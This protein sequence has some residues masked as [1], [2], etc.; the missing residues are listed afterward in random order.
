MR[1]LLLLVLTALC[2]HVNATTYYL[3]SSVGNDSNNGTSSSSPWKTLNKL[4]SFAASLKPGDKVLFNRGDIFYGNITITAAGT[5]SSVITYGTYGSG[6]APIIS[7]FSNVTAWTNLGGN[8]WESTNAISGLSSC[9]YVL[10][11]NKSTTMGRTPNAGSFYYYTSH[12]GTTSITSSS[13]NS[14]TTNWT[15]ADIAIWIDRE[16]NLRLPITGHSGN[17]ITFSN[18]VNSGITPVNNFAFFIENDPRTLDAQNEWYYNPSTKKIR[19][20]STS[21]PSNV[22]IATVSDVILGNACDYIV[23]DG[24]NIQGANH[25]GIYFTGTT[26]NVTVQNCTLNYCGYNGIETSNG[27]YD[28]VTYCNINNCGKTGIFLLG[29]YSSATYNTTNHCGDV[30]GKVD[31]GTQGS[32]ILINSPSAIVSYNV[33]KNSGSNG[34]F[35]SNHQIGTGGVVSYNFIDSSLL[36]NTDNGGIYTSAQSV[37]VLIDHNIITNSV[38]K[39]DIASPACANLSEVIYLDEGTG[40]SQYAVVTNNSVAYCGDAGLKIHKNGH[41]RIENNTFFGNI[42][43][44]AIIQDENSTQTITADTLRNNIFFCTNY[45]ASTLE[46]W[47]IQ[48]TSMS[49]NISGLGLFDN[50]YYARPLN[51]GNLFTTQIS[52]G[53]SIRDF[54]GWKSYTGF[55]SHSTLSSKTTTNIND[56]KLVYNNTTST[57]SYALDAVYS[58]LKGNTYNGSVTLNPFNSVALIKTG[59]LAN[60]LPVAH[61]GSDQT[62]TLPINSVTLTA[63]GTDSDGVITAY[64]WTKISGPSGYS[65][66]SPA[67]ATTLVSGL[68]QGIYQFQLTVTDNAGGTGK[69]TV[70]VTVNAAPNQ[71]PVANAGADQAITL[72]LNNISLNGSG[73][74]A[75]GTVVSYQWTK[76][77]GPASYNI[78]SPNSANTSVTG[79]VQGT[80][81]FQLQVTDNNGATGIDVMILTVNPAPNIPPVANAGSNQT[82]ILPV[83]STTLSGSGTDA[84]GTVVGYLW[85]ELSGPSSASIVSSG[86]ASTN[87]TGLVQGTYQFQLQVTDNDGAVGSATVQ[88]IVNP[89]VNIP[90]T[91]NA[92]SNQTITL[93]VNSVTL[94]G[95]GSDADGTVVGYAWTQLSGPSAGN[96]INA[97]STTTNI[98]NLVQGVYQ[99]QLQVTDNSGAVGNASVQVTVNAAANIPPVA[100]A[101]A[102]QVITLPVNSIT[103][104]GSGTDSDGIIVSYQWTELSGPSSYSFA[105]ANSATTNVNGLIQG[106]YQFQLQVTDNVGATGIAVVQVTVNPAANIPPVANAGP[107][108]AINLPTD[109]VM[110]TGSGT[111][112]DGSIVSYQWTE[113]SGPLSYNISNTSSPSTAVTGLIQG[114]YQFQLQVTDNSGATAIASVQ[115]TVNAAANIPPVANAGSNQTIT[116]PSDSVILTGSGTDADGTVVNYLWTKISGPSSYSIT[117]PNAATTNVTGLVQGT[118]QFQLQVTD[119]LGATGTAIVSVTVNASTNIAPVANAGSNQT[120]KLPVDSVKL[121]GSGTDAD[122]TIVSYQWTQTSGPSSYIIINPGNAT[123]EVIGLVSGIYY[124]QLTVTD[125]DGA[126]NSSSVKITV[127]SGSNIPPVANAGT[128]QTI[129]LPTDSITLTGTGTDADGSVVSYQWAKISGPSSSNIISPAS[130][131]TQVTALVQGIYQFQLTVTDNKGAIGTSTVQ[132]TVN[133]AVN[134]PPVADAGPDQ[135]VI[136]PKDSTTVTGSGTDADGTIISYQWSEISGPSSYS[137]ANA[138]AAITSITGLV[139]GVYQFQL[140]VTDNGGASATSIVQITVNPAANIPPVANAGA[141]QVITL[142]LDSVALSGSGTDADGTIVS[143]QWS[144]ISG[145]SSYNIINTNAAT[146]SI[147]GLVQ[148]IYQF[149]LQVTDNNGA[150]GAAV[151][152]ITVNA[153]PNIPPVAN[154]GPDQTITLPASSVTLTGSGSDA[155][156][157]IAS[158]QWTEISGPSAATIAN[159]NTATT[160]VSGLVQ[161]VYQFELQVIDNNGA[162]ASDTVMITVNAA[163]NILPTANA[164][165][166]QT[167]TL[168]VNSVTLTG[169]GTDADGTIVS[170]QWS[171]ISGPAGSTITTPNLPN[172]NITGLVQGVYQFQLTVT[173]N[174]GGTGT[175]SVQVTVNAALN[176]PPVANAG[177]DQSI[178]LPTNSVTLN[179]IGTDIDGTVVS[180]QWSEV[181]GPSSYTI[182][183]ANAALTSITGLVQGVYQFQLKVTDNNGAIATD[184]VQII[185]NPAPNQPPVANAGV[186][187]SITLPVN[188]VTLN[189]SGTDADGSVVAYSWTKISGPASYTIVNANAATTDIT[190]LNKGTYQ[191]QLKVTDNN[192]AIGT[193]VVQIIVNPAPNKPPTAHVNNTNKTVTLP[194]NSTTIS[195]GGTDSDGTIVSYQW[196]L[197]SGPTG[198]VIANAT[199]SATT[200]TNLVQ[201]TYKFQLQVTDN[202]GATANAVM[203]INVDPAPN[204]PPVANAG[205]D[206]VI[207][208]PVNSVTLTGAGTDSDGTVVA[209]QWSKVSGPS[210]FTIANANSDTTNVSGLVAGTYQFQLKVTDNNGASAIDL[211]NV[212]VNPAPNQPPVANAGADQTITLPINTVTLNGIGTDADGSIVSYKWTKVSGPSSFTIVNA[213]AASTNIS[214][215][216]QGTYQFQLEVTDNS[217]AKSDDVM[218][219]TVNPP[220]NQ[221]PTA[222]AGPDQIITLPTNSVILSGSGTDSDGTIAAYQWTKISGPT[223]YSFVS[224][225]AAATIVGGLTAG[226]YL[227]E[228][229]VTDNNGARGRDTVQ[230]IVNPAPNIPPS[231]SAGN[232]QTITLPTNTVSLTGAAVDADGT[233]VAYKWTKISGP[234][235]YNITNANSPVT[236]AWNLT[237]GVYQ[238]VLT[239]TDNSGADASDTVSITVISLANIPPVADAGSDI[240][241]TL[242]Q[243]TTQLAGSGTDADGIIA[244]YSWKQLTGPSQSSLAAPN[245]AYTEV[246]GLIGG[247]YEFEL[248]VTDNLG[249][250]GK[251]T[252]FV[253]VTEPRLNTSVSPNKITA[254]PNPVVDI[255]TLQINTGHVYA[256]L[257]IT[258]ED[259]NGNVIMQRQV[260][261]SSTTITQQINLSNRAKG[262]YVITVYYGK[263]ELQSIKVMKE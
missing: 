230:V 113:L 148:G 187:Q 122:G 96:I 135:T 3:S 91:A 190:G 98:T 18:T 40:N 209:Y 236:S 139:Q 162:T 114:V 157:T 16:Y 193:D 239:V 252:M 152:Q 179:G 24:L 172:T 127:K 195:G 218:Q 170:Y 65:I 133:A 125:N 62:I 120:I 13:V 74:D 131:T 219:I 15:G 14:A 140:Q 227:F 130:A 75:D 253:I 2:V 29:S 240:T 89:A 100:Y 260:S 186:D 110:L 178:T 7:G 85:T 167:I 54:P 192:G 53:G 77:S 138:N 175:A 197:L 196:S 115:I 32:G 56:L 174:N 164:G 188:T 123:T 237:R 94:S 30:E 87:I 150:V 204:Q 124:F 151:V 93:P 181:S 145:P 173:D 246:T 71:P 183:N 221:P 177:P 59:T 10:I 60:K 220:A 118:Y 213:N 232:D 161:G 176:I 19:I 251:D 241:I 45:S 17:T 26:N 259:V 233:I 95:T 106:V 212:T 153:A 154:A 41:N 207:T 199:D 129:T 198:S 262:L 12:S 84:D 20:Y 229:R 36:L 121:T 224:A 6:A 191:F 38:G 42:R 254:Y 31:N 256:N 61:A 155:D 142:P 1:S 50:N 257:L 200:V 109:S 158:Y 160:N 231:V 11:N 52:S 263:N 90:P 126:T 189:G 82:I 5:S 67:S 23:I 147:T 28:L 8:I 247:T 166:D 112:A 243:D 88:V 66:A 9:N 203:Q 57:A 156:G 81:Q 226:T 168:P 215:L 171:E 163:A 58:D 97:N 201:G 70:Q 69:D 111:D 228:L 102:N 211:V 35:F 261:P 141:D 185:V 149:Q 255:T 78:T 105:N 210:S 128:D 25:D 206:E 64:A 46:S 244:S 223:S 214:G 51:I 222:S 242:P 107:D 180:Y 76:I 250:V 68:V 208:L 63:S 137:I 55:D 136:L 134:Q 43:N 116:L 235:S 119:N 49:N 39:T 225:T 194:T 234:S 73:T 146:T 99:F 4:N 217:G 165:T 33:I 72:P 182:V 101:G 37:G 169:S 245:N 92:G 202:N 47:I 21:T 238:F 22:Q 48:A 86:S 83:N 27:D 79:L 80:Y 34:I 104:N 159:A 144:E 216:V 258:V 103:L 143:Y 117:N 44:G 108:Q 132:I 248:T 205:A 184:I 249:A